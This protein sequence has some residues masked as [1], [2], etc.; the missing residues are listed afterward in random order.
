MVRLSGRMKKLI[1]SY[2]LDDLGMTTTRTVL[3]CVNISFVLIEYLSD[4]SDSL[5]L[6]NTD[7][8]FPY[9]LTNRHISGYIFISTDSFLFESF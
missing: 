7:L 2:L 1:R 4:I 6:P 8:R 9:I 3:K 5:N